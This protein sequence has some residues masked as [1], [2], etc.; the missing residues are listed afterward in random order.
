M[1]KRLIYMP[2]LGWCAI[3]IKSCD[4]IDRIGKK[5]RQLGWGGRGKEGTI[6]VAMCHK[7]CPQNGTKGFSAG[8]NGEMRVQFTQSQSDAFKA[9]EILYFLIRRVINTDLI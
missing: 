7:M 9:K 5:L 2:G 6:I 8:G 4:G 3:V 1:L